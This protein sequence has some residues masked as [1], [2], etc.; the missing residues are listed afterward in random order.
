[1]INESNGKIV[2][3]AQEDKR[4]EVA[5]E[6]AKTVNNLSE[7]LKNMETSISNIHINGCNIQTAQGETALQIGSNVKNSVVSNSMFTSTY[8]Q[9]EHDK[10]ENY[11][12]DDDFED[13]DD[14]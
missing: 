2:I 8:D 5:I 1:M 9:S 10:D 14:E 6:L 13:E 11:Y 7:M 4:L 3:Q 12:N